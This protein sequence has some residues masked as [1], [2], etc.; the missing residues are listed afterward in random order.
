MKDPV[1]FRSYF[2]NN[3]F[4]NHF[5]SRVGISTM[6]SSRWTSNLM[7]RSTC[8]NNV[9]LG[10]T[11]P[12][13]ICAQ[14]VCYRAFASTVPYIHFSASQRISLFR[15]TVSSPR[16]GAPQ[17]LVAAVLLE[18]A[19]GWC[20]TMQEFA[21]FP[22]L[23]CGRVT[24]KRKKRFHTFQRWHSAE[25]FSCR[26]NIR[27]LHDPLELTHDQTVLRVALIN[28]CST[29]GH[30]V[31]SFC[32]MS[33][34]GRAQ[35]RPCHETIR[36]FIVLLVSLFPPWALRHARHQQRLLVPGKLR[37]DLFQ[38]HFHAIVR[39]R[40]RQP[41]Y[42]FSHLYWFTRHQIPATHGSFDSEKTWLCNE[43]LIT[44]FI[45]GRRVRWIFEDE[46]ITTMHLFEALAHN[47]YEMRSCCDNCVLRG[48]QL[49]WFS[50]VCYCVKTS[51]TVGMMDMLPIF[52]GFAVLHVSRRG[53]VAGFHETSHRFPARNSWKCIWC[54][55][56]ICQ[57]LKVFGLT[58]FI[59]EEFQLCPRWRVGFQHSWKE[60]HLF[61]PCRQHSR[62]W[63]QK[64]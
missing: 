45:P 13:R 29:Q 35:K 5:S 36:L 37:R 9:V 26:G 11:V 48:L 60:E 22:L 32:T 42:R 50:N 7:S 39:T 27:F 47:K 43:L 56:K 12:L 38:T 20:R 49:V 17:I 54:Q 58:S 25:E 6:E 40:V 15:A 46:V 63:S 30:C 64:N 2:E 3:T 21:C 16:P 33:Y 53:L 52:F 24:E 34:E 19:R 61:V 51:R 55:H 8:T 23:D 57:F 59:E 41:W 62:S 44:H 28:V 4:S 1:H 14:C 18:S 31:D 10:G